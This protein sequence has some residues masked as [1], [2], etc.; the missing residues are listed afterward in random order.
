VFSKAGIGS[1]TEARSWIGKERIGVNGRIVKNAVDLE[2]DR[3]RRMPNEAKC[4]GVSERLSL[5]S[6]LLEK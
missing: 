2:R 3:R 1:R 4:L 6:H 5:N